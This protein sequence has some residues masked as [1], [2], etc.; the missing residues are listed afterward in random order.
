MGKNLLRLLI[1]GLSLLH[2]SKTEAQ[3]YVE[4]G[5]GAYAVDI[6]NCGT[7]ST[8]LNNEFVD[9]Y[10]MAADPDGN[11][12]YMD[13]DGIVQIEA[14]TGNTNLI[15]VLPSDFLPVSMVYGADGLIYTS[16][17]G[18]NG[19][20][21]ETL[22]VVDPATGTFTILGEL[23]AGFV[24]EGD[25][26]FYQGQLY[27]LAVDAN[28]NSVMLQIP[29]GNPAATVVVFNYP[30]LAGLIGG[31]SV[32]F[33]GVETV[34]MLGFD[35]ITNQ[36]GLYQ[37]NMSTGVATLF[38]P[39]FSGGD[40]A[41]PPDFEIS[42]CANFAGNLS[43]L[44]LTT[45]CLNQDISLDH[46]GDEVLD[47]DA[48]LSFVLVADSN[49]TLPN[50]IVQISANPTFSFDAATMNLNQIYFV[51]PV[52]APGS[53]GNPNWFAGCIDVGY[54]APVQWVATPTVS[55]SVPQN[56]ICAGECQD[57]AVTF[58]GSP[59]FNLTYN[60]PLGQ[61]TQT[62]GTNSGILAICP[63]PGFLGVLTLEALRLE[64][65]NCLCE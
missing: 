63:P 44:N 47:A 65:A 12:Y 64:D 6:C 1:I 57:V 18:L 43:S 2:F 35:P 10:T 62:F 11:V 14:S 34:F 46:L 37:V 7:A 30:N 15:A 31:I 53:P 13:L 60:S 61:Q 54:F 38:C 24:L 25:L 50:D 39:N 8:P 40:L 22:I 59:P 45:V 51:A 48:A 36:N 41:A 4:Y 52:A 49:T 19:S 27:G 20:V 5:D 32:L 56:D 55:F 26:F 58:T 17:P 16:A 28:A 23:P 29:I 9:P 21:N 3:V 33:N 42:C